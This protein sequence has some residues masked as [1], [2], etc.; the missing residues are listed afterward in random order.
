M[1][2]YNPEWLWNCHIVTG[3]YFIFAISGQC[4]FSALW[5]HR[6]NRFLVHLEG[7]LSIIGNFF[8]SS[9]NFPPQETGHSEQQTGR[10]Y[11]QL[12]EVGVSI[13]PNRL[14]KKYIKEKSLGQLSVSAP[15][16]H[17]IHDSAVTKYWEVCAW[18]VGTLAF[19]FYFLFTH[20]HTGGQLEGSICSKD[21]FLF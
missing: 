19:Y 16:P 6:Q 1:T 17:T 14:F 3:I 7:M 5:K 15:W 12:W 8:L 20:P 9:R 2:N 18:V 21:C 10:T 11:Q 4:L 13:T